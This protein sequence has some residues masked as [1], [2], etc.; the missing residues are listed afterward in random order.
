[1]A[2][3]DKLHGGVEHR[4][5]L[6][7]S[8]PISVLLLSFTLA[9]V[10]LLGVYGCGDPASE[11]AFVPPPLYDYGTTN[12][13]PTNISVATF[14]V[15]RFFDTQCDSRR[16]SGNNPYE[17]LYSEAEFTAKARQLAAGVMELNADFVLLQEVETEVCLNT[18]V[19]FLDV[20]RYPVSVLGE[21][22]ASA[23]LDVA[24]VGHGRI[25]EQRSHIMRPIPKPNGVMTTFSREFLELHLDINGRR[26]II[27]NA[28]FKAKIN[29]DPERRYAE[30]AASR[31]IVLERVAEFPEALI[32]MGG[33]LN[34]TPGSGPITALEGTG[35]LTRVASELGPDAATYVWRSTPQIIDHLYLVNSD[36]GDYVQGTAAVVRSSQRGLAGSDHAGLRAEF[37]LTGA[38]EFPDSRP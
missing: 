18:L 2:I 35:G 3:L 16:C 33:D 26:L 27:F 19:E 15:R 38:I 25:I 21:T 14:N 1:M 37:Q 24:T 32:I 20:N 29:D 7:R 6:N 17:R 13:E 10:S 34:D 12:V 28:H 8:Q 36:G 5:V 31:E 23:S 11:P 4:M 22:G 30:G 9:A